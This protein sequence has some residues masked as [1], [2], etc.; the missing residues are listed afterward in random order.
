MMGQMVFSNVVHRPVRTIVSIL[1]VAVQVILVI[2]VVGLTSGM[3]ENYGKRME[4]IGADIMLQPPSAQV[5]ISFS[6]APMPMKL[7]DKLAEIKY[8]QAYTPVLLQF[9]LSGSVDNLWGIDP[10]SFNAVS[11]GFVF[12]SGHDLQAPYDMLIDDVVA[13]SKHLAAGDTFNVLDHNFNIAGVVE[14]GKGGRIFVQLATLQDLTASTDKA[15][16]FFIRC[17]RP[18][19][20]AAVMDQMREIFRG[21]PISPLK[22]YLSLVTQSNLPGLDA[23]VR[24]MIGLAVAI[25][26]LVI[27]LSMYTTVIERTR[28]VGILKSIGASKGYIVKALL[29]ETMLICGVGIVLGIILS[30]AARSAF[31]SAY[32][33]ISI[34]ITISW[35]VRAAAISVGASLLGATYPSYLASGKDPVEALA[36][37]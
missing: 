10:A 35:I 9:N 14:H 6:G 1:A 15:S 26:F 32:P 8:V 37:D 17:T 33:T 34:N 28:D 24:S 2:I 30:Y 31:I 36:Y 5:I 3:M 22:D 4:G 29:G 18:E 21:Y 16:V 12:L 19:R 27:F 23:F 20:T 13:K 11:G 7:G 25:G